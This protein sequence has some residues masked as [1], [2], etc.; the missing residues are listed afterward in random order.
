[1]EGDVIRHLRGAQ[2]EISHYHTAGNPG[3]ND[4]DDSQEIHYPG[5]LQAI[6]ATGYGGFV[7]HEFIAKGDPAAALKHAFELGAKWLI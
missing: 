3:R 4:L 1:M 2:D 7:T 6:A 5:V